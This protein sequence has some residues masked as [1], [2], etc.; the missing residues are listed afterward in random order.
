MKP[1]AMHVSTIL[2]RS[3]ALPVWQRVPITTLRMSHPKIWRLQRRGSMVAFIA[4]P[5]S[6]RYMRIED[7]RVVCDAHCNADHP[8]QPAPDAGNGGSLEILN[9]FSEIRVLLTFPE[10]GLHAVLE[11]DRGQ[12]RVHDVN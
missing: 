12:F 10:D 4:C 11:V 1:H 2:A 5:C 3:P 6:G 8:R 7:G 9:S